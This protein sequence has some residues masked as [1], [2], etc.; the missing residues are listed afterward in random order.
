MVH[1][2]DMTSTGTDLD[3]WAY[4]FASNALA[5]SVP[6][7]AAP[8]NHDFLKDGGANFRYFF[9]RPD[10]CSIDY[11]DCRIILLHPYDGPGRTLDGPVICSGAEQYRWVTRELARPRHGKWLIV[12]LHNPLLSTGDYGV[13]ELLAEQYLSLFRKHRVDLVVSGHDH[14]FDAFLAGSNTPWGGTLYLVTGTGGSH[15]DAAIMDRPERRWLDWRQDRSTG[16]G[17]YQRRSFHEKLSPLRRA[18][19]G[20]HR[21]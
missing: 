1:G 8:G 20:V 19:L 9:N 3:G 15:L 18:L 11:G 5:D 6:L 21:G 13:N 10:Y 7:V 12:V 16:Q 4:S 17:P 14:N 2:G